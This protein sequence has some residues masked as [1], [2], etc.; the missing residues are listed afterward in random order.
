M[1]NHMQNSNVI[2]VGQSVTEDT[3]RQLEWERKFNAR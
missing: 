1:V 2:D 3:D